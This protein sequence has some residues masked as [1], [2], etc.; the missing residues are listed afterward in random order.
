MIELVIDNGLE[1]EGIFGYFKFIKNDNIMFVDKRW[2][3][4]IVYGFLFDCFKNKKFV[5][6]FG[7]ERYLF[8]GVQ[9]RFFFDLIVYRLGG[10]VKFI[11]KRILYLY[12]NFKYGIYGLFVK[13]KMFDF[14]VYDFGLF[15]GFLKRILDFIY[16]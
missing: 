16:S 10:F 2:F 9:K 7:F 3:D 15:G 4:F 12:G 5:D 1:I 13:K 8:S 6:F 14:I 11:F